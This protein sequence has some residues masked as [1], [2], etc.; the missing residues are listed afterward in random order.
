M[1]R[2]RR[3]WTAAMAVL[4]ATPAAAQFRWIELGGRDL[5]GRSEQALIPVRVGDL[6]SRIRL[7]VDR[8]QVRFDDVAV[9]FRRGG[10]QQLPVRAM[11]GRGACT[12]SLDLDGGRREIESVI[13]SYQ[14]VSIGRSR[15]RV[16]LIAS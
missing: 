3:Y 4:L 15:A 1:A 12:E 9:R 7:C 8:A 6:Y 5:T 13:V 16:R 14:A 11:V 2:A 10:A